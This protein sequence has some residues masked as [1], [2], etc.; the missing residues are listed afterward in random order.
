M[1]QTLLLPLTIVLLTSGCET[2]GAFVNPDPLPTEAEETLCN[3]LREVAPTYS[4]LD[5]LETN[6]ALCPE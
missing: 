5:T 1:K 4:A 6:N 2:L 3:K